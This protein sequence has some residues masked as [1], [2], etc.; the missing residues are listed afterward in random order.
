MSAPIARDEI[1]H[2]GKT[3][4]VSTI[5]RQSSAVAAYGAIYA[6]TMVAEIDEHKRWVNLIAKD[7]ASQD[8]TSGHERMVAWVKGGMKAEEDQ[9]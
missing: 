6:E 2:E 1:Q 8:S 3:I 9:A 7:W 5:N 4:L